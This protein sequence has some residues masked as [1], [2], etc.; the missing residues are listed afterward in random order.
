MSETMRLL[1][2]SL[3][4]ILVNTIA[5]TTDERLQSALPTNKRNL[6]VECNQVFVSWSMD[7]VY[8][9]VE[10]AILETLGDDTSEAAFAGATLL[11]AIEYGVQ[12]R[13]ICAKCTDFSLLSQPLAYEE[14]CNGYGSDITFSGL[15][16]IPLV[17]NASSFL[18]G[19]HPGG[20]FCHGTSTRNVPS[21]DFAGDDSPIDIMIN[22]A[23]ASTGTIVLMPDYMGY[24]ESSALIYKA[25]LVKKQY[26]T[27]II[28]LWLMADQLI[29]D[30]SNCTTALANAAAVLGYSEGGYAAVALA[31]AL[32]AMGVD[33]IKVEAGAGPYK[34]ASATML[35]VVERSDNGT[36]PSNVRHYFALVGAAYSSTYPE[37]ANFEVGQ[38]TLAPE[39]REE[40][41]GLVTNSSTAEEIQ[42][43]IP[44]DDPLSVMSPDMV[45]FV[46]EAI[47]NDY[48][49]P[50]SGDKVVEGFNDLLCDALNDND[51]TELLETTEYPVR[52]CHSPDDEIV[53]FENLPDFEANAL[54][55]FLPATGTHAEAGVLCLLQSVF[56]MLS[57][58][59]QD[60]QFE[61]KDT[62]G[63]CLGI[64]SI[65]SSSP[66]GLGD[67]PAPSA[68]SKAPSFAPRLCNEVLSSW[69]ATE[70]KSL[71]TQLFS[72]MFGEDSQEFA[73][74][75]LSVDSLVYGVEV[76]KL[77]ASC[78]EFNVTSDSYSEYCGEGVYGYS[79][80][81]SGLLMI[82]MSIDGTVMAEGTFPGVVFNHDPTMN[83][84]PSE[85]WNGANSMASEIMF[86]V[87]PAAAGSVA[88]LPD[89]FGH[90]ES[91]GALFK[92]NLVKQSYETSTVP[93]WLKADAIIAESSDCGNAALANAATVTGF[94]E[95]GYA[96]VVI[97][98]ALYRLGVDIIRVQAGA[99]PSRMGSV[100]IPTMV[101]SFDI[102]TFPLMD[103]FLLALLGSAYSA[104]F[105]DLPNYEEG[106][107]LLNDTARDDI[108]KLVTEASSKDDL[109]EAIPMDDPLSI[110]DGIVLEWARNAY[111]QNEADPC[112]TDFVQGLEG[113]VDM[114]AA[115]TA[116]DL[117]A[118]IE[119]AQYNVFLC[120]SPNDE[121]VSVANLPDA[122]A[123]DNI[124]ISLVEGSHFESR[125][126][127]MSQTTAFL[128]GPIYT[129]YPI[130][131]KHKEGGCD[132]SSAEMD[133]SMSPTVEPTLSGAYRLPSVLLVSLLSFSS[134]MWW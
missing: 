102:G 54:L 36:F 88:V 95:G 80:T 72:D 79:A 13:K 131:P 111:E 51:L 84:V 104:T 33:I 23:I 115:L 122:S 39:S 63:G 52:L 98:N 125:G 109:D 129:G 31:Q 7:E 112:S 97:A 15:L 118:L 62:E 94:S 133:P 49:S 8:S 81:H 61:A 55:E 74:F 73:L 105:T 100:H 67:S 60:S 71:V 96:S 93:L 127:C 65:E 5:F 117:T 25:Y 30:E 87:Y 59:F 123:N 21:T 77:C 132:A 116:N 106:A 14:F 17:P 12:V 47:A 99:V 38:D 22:L 1:T 40:I 124:T 119:S 27:S 9:I 108:V 126:T 83:R 48:A 35:S 4:T 20:I 37:L 120:H 89:Y 101:E 110:L 29:Q 26:H 50:C 130:E 34:I 53:S 32:Y 75:L 85:E 45:S 90:G 3:A 56:F 64:V 43:A 92:A 82:P 16:M 91:N 18:A 44:I 28:P 86:G 41:V 68:V 58:D 70:V 57:S 103:R 69:N 2:L 46:R 134:I 114:C 11:P 76:R 10:T 107:Y 113:F 42:A 19:T 66:S 78:N 6:Q 24:G 121:V 128:S